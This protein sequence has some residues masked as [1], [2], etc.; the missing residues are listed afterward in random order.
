MKISVV[1]LFPELYKPFFSTSLVKRAQDAHIIDTHVYNLFSYAEPKQR[2]DGPTFGHGAGMVIKPEII[3]KA[4]TD[5]Q[6][7]HGSAFKIFFSPRGKKLDQKLLGNLYKRMLEQEKDHLMLLPARYEGMD[8]RIETE[9]ADEIISIGDFV[10]M[11]GDVP[12]MVFIE[13]L[14]RFIPAI[15]GKS[16]SVEQDS[17]SGPF[18][19]YPE[20]TTPVMWKGHEV[21]E[22]LRSGNHKAIADWRHQEV[23][24]ESVLHHFEWVRGYPHVT[25]EQEHLI[26]KNIP[27]HYVVLMHSDVLVSQDKVNTKVGTTSVTS[28][29][30]HDIARSCTTYGIKNYFIVTPLIDQQVIVKTLLGFWQEGP[31]ISYNN[32]RHEALSNVI[33]ETNLDNVIAQITQREGKVPVLIATAAKKGTHQRLINFFDQERVWSCERPVLIVLGTGRGLTPELIERCDYRLVPIEGFSSFNHLSV[34]SAAAVLF[35]RWLGKN[36]KRAL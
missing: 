3:E 23:A 11:G 17:F 21:P 34:R 30:I 18:V 24:R 19:D 1:T 20:Y 33:L 7:Q 35:D 29:D 32:Y 5:I 28:L 12:A 15:V 14:L 22:L 9:Y 10:L 27:A 8:A 26:Q 36:P 31:G 16:E 13:G 25:P 2:I 4:V 6:G